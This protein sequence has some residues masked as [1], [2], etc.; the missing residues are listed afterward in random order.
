MY[1][2]L[3]P[4]VDLNDRPEGSREVR[5]P[6]VGAEDILNFRKRPTGGW[7]LGEWVVS[8]CRDFCRRS[9]ARLKHHVPTC[10]R[11]LARDNDSSAKPTCS[12][13]ID[14]PINSSCSNLVKII[15]SLWLRSNAQSDL[16]Q[17]RSRKHPT[18][19]RSQ[20]EGNFWFFKL[21]V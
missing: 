19:L 18:D 21:Q 5:H 2:R 1:E 6:Q 16:G 13:R 7:I 9:H 11:D 4:V 15:I 3:N 20:A 12:L 14:V 17:V 8:E 10:R